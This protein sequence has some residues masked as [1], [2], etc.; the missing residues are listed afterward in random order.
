M[1]EQRQYYPPPATKFAVPN[2]S[3][4][5]VPRPRLEMRL[6]RG[7]TRKLTVVTGPAGFGKTSLVAAWLQTCPVD[8]VW[9]QTGDDDND[10][11]RFLDAVVTGLQYIYPGFGE[12]ILAVMHG[13]G[14][15]PLDNILALIANELSNADRETV[16]V[17]D[18]LHVIYNREIHRLLEQLVN[19]VPLQVHLFF[20]SRNKPPVALSKLRV[21]RQ[22]TEVRS[23]DLSFTAAETR[24]L[25][26]EKRRLS[27]SEDSISTLYEV[28]EGWV[29]GLHMAM[30]SLQE[31][32]DADGFIAELNGTVRE[33]FDYLDEEVFSMQPSSVRRF[34]LET[35]ILESFNA[36]LCEA[37]TGQ[38]KAAEMLRKLEAANLFIIPLDNYR[39]WYRYH[40]F[41]A[42][43][44]RQRL[45]TEYG[46]PR[47]AELH[48]RA[49]QWYSE[50]NQ[51]AAAV[52]QALA[53]G[54][55]E[56]AAD[57]IEPLAESIVRMRE[58]RLLQQWLDAIP[59]SVILA[60][61]VLLLYKALLLA[62]NAAF[63]KLSSYL[64]RIEKDLSS[65]R[66]KQSGSQPL[67][68]EPLYRGR[69]L[70]LQGLLACTRFHFKEA[71]R[72]A[73]KAL[74]L[75][76]GQ[77][78]A[79][80]LLAL[81][82]KGFTYY[83]DG[84]LQE[85]RAIFFKLRR[86]C[87]EMHSATLEYCTLAVLCILEIP[88]GNLRRAE[89]MIANA[90]REYDDRHKPGEYN[91]EYGLLL[92]LQS[93]VY[94]ERYQLDQ[95]EDCLIQG[96][97]LSKNFLPRGVVAFGYMIL[98]YVFFSRERP[99]DARNAIASAE[100]LFPVISFPFTFIPQLL[101]GQIYI[102]AGEWEAVERLLGVQKVEEAHWQQLYDK[103]GI[104]NYQQLLARYLIASG[105]ADR[106]ITLLQQIEEKHG[107]HDY[108]V[109]RIQV[110]QTL[111][112]YALGDHEAVTQTMVRALPK[113]VPE[114]YIRVFVEEGRPMREILHLLRSHDLLE[115]R[116]YPFVDELNGYLQQ[117][118]PER[119]RS[120]GTPSPADLLPWTYRLDPLSDREIEVLTQI[121][122]G[123]N[124]KDIA[125]N[126]YISVNTVKT[127]VSKILSKLDAKNR[128]A[129]V[130]KAREMGLITRAGD[131]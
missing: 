101:R 56:T 30:L 39:Q 129:A 52:G 37:V 51:P 116:F 102:A 88:G 119:E 50:N 27:L 62:D 29:A 131:H 61:P 23:R 75:L 31:R 98:A 46:E 97:R 5:F 47:V 34:L 105:R 85:T 6:D 21:D 110:L 44:L 81:S 82:L 11:V 86:L 63:G 43:G 67:I 107:Q 3:P 8:R 9:M 70:A 87:R 54:Y 20:I 100:S 16:L 14:S 79:F 109:L 24:Q 128:T 96:L 80:T 25:L 94:W 113:A 7:L 48:I 38:K 93:I 55:F 15:P 26:I 45:A 65:F 64:D 122:H 22:I 90:L 99:E 89:T 68:A 1:S 42:D 121:S 73:E 117:R 125:E 74:T 77:T 127:H 72:L 76:E 115:E 60:R 92:I 33:I 58:V 126:L 2:L 32:E 19:F 124:N 40:S 18:D 103:I 12:N 49:S 130:H 108:R 28:T 120:V 17:F 83:I 91:A 69:I 106:A 104:T 71:R 66:Q 78:C 53:A 13:I 35:S 36:P 118:Y 111:A 95:A 10:P 4:L 114:G 112:Y 59:E 84:E 41:F 123:L 57:I